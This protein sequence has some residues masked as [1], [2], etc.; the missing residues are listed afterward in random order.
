MSNAELDQLRRAA[1]AQH[2]LAPE[3][4]RFL[5]GTSLGKLE[6]SASA[7]AQLIGAREQQEPDDDLADLFSPT[8]R[9]AHKER[10]GKA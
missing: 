8:A 5:V 1:A 10:P 7:L 2:G 3:A 6:E 9:A 4:E